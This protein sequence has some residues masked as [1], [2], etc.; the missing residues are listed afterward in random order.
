MDNRDPEIV[1]KHW[2]ALCHLLGLCGL[3]FP[4]GSI[5]G[6]LTV[7]LARKDDME[8]VDREGRIALNFQLSVGLYFWISFGVWYATS[9][10]ALLPAVF[11]WVAIWGPFWF[12][13]TLRG[14]VGFFRSGRASYPFALRMLKLERER[15]P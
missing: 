10:Y 7:W 3:A 4:F 11:V 6:P 15:D 2:G 12:F 5:L 8:T 13:L 14:I 1:A 9:S